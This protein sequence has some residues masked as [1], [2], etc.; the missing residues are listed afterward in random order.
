MEINQWQTKFMCKVI[1]PE[2]IFYW[3]TVI[4]RTRVHGAHYLLPYNIKLERL[5]DTDNFFYGFWIGPDPKPTF[6]DGVFISIGEGKWRRL[7]APDD[8]TSHIYRFYQVTYRLL[9]R[10]KKSWYYNTRG[11]RVEYTVP[12]YD[13]KIY[14]FKDEDKK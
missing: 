1:I 11:E 7:E 12:Q 3:I 13:E 6:C 14:E 2:Y 8:Y 5:E 10:G 9:M 4:G